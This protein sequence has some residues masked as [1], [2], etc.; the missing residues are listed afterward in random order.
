[1]PEAIPQKSLRMVKQLLFKYLQG[2]GTHSPM[3]D[4]APFLDCFNLNIRNFFFY[5]LGRESR[6]K[7]I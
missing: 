2:W 6:K 3:K 4:S 7:N 1:M 5:S